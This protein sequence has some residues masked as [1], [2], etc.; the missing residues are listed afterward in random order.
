MTV[1]DDKPWVGGLLLA[2]GGSSRLGRPKQLVEFDGKT[3]IRRAAEALLDA[4]C[5]PVVVVLGA[6]VERSRQ[7]LE[8]LSVEIVENVDWGR[9]MGSSIG[10]GIKL[11]LDIEPFIDAVLI[12]VC[13]QPFITADELG[14]FIDLFEKKRPSIIA[15]EYNGILG[16]PALFSSFWE[17]ADLGGERGAREI[18][19]NSP[20][21]LTI[22]L[23][24]AGIDVD[25]NDD[26]AKLLT[27]HYS[28]S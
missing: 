17:L 8:S 19:R 1:S 14:L 27:P 9:G 15:A 6:E 24:A 28:S 13:D 11:T 16:V 25:T 26:A 21:A 10:V 20:D 18:I 3:L 2:A 5:Y 4:G 22:P 12:S 7:E 23:P